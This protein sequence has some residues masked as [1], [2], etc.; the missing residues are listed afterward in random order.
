MYT[1]F[2]NNNNNYKNNNNQEY[3]NTTSL[4]NYEV[5]MKPFFY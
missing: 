3:L 1:F 4:K 5:Y 2:L